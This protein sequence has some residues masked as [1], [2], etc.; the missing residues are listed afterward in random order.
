MVVTAS[1]VYELLCALIESTEELMEALDG[2]T[3]KIT[4]V[5]ALKSEG[6]GAGD[7]YSE[8]AHQRLPHKG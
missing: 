7:V 5:K 8:Q 4:E 1:D 6:C 2:S 3:P